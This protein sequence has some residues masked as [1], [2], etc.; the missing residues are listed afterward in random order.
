MVCAVGIGLAL[1]PDAYAEI[2][3]ARSPCPHL[4]SA[5][6]GSFVGTAAI[7]ALIV[8]FLCMV[9]RRYRIGSVFLLVAVGEIGL[10]AVL[11][12]NFCDCPPF[13]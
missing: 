4:T 9:A 8:G 11:D 12:T 7:C 13:D 1:F 2:V 3:P 10:C 6:L 5:R